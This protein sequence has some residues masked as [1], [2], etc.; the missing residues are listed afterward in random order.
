MGI[1]QMTRT[2]CSRQRSWHILSHGCE[3]LLAYP[4]DR[5][6]VLGGSGQ[7][8]LVMKDIMNHTKLFEL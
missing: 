3:E 8:D 6:E 4:K 5:K 2:E 7:N 1:S